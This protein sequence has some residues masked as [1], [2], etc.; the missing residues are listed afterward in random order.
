VRALGRDEHDGARVAGRDETLEQRRLHGLD[1]R[2]DEPTLAVGDM[3]GTPTAKLV[4]CAVER[5]CCGVAVDFL[6]SRL[7]DPKGL[8]F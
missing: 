5:K 7:R 4:D 2:D 1:G 3:Y 8:C 6:V